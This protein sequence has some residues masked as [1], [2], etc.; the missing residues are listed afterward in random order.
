MIR[1]AILLLLVF[2]SLPTGA[3]G[4]SV[5]WTAF[6]HL[7]DS[8]RVERKPLLIFVRADWCKYCKMQEHTTFRD[9]ALVQALNRW[10]YCLRLDAE[11]KRDIRFLG[12]T[13]RYRPTGAQAGYHELAEALARENGEVCFPTTVVLSEDLRPLQ[14]YKGCVRAAE[15]RE[16]LPV[17]NLENG[18]AERPDGGN[19]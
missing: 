11:T 8:L 5:K 16:L 13:Y 12:R 1:L 17:R 15:L 14:R 10:F 18:K 3:L 2:I 19:H 6:E 9:R 4:Q 7:S